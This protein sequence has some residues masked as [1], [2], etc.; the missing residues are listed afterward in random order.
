MPPHPPFPP[1]SYRD[2]ERERDRELSSPVGYGHYHDRERN[3]DRDYYRP[4]P[5]R[6]GSPPDYERFRGR[7][8]RSERP[9]AWGPPSGPSGYGQSR[10][11]SSRGR[12]KEDPRSPRASSAAIMHPRPR[13]REDSFSDRR[14]DTAPPPKS[15]FD[16]TFPPRRP[17]PCTFAQTIFTNYTILLAILFN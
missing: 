10:R 5:P 7:P 6:P 11:D 9:P 12:E 17:S 4:P 16:S 2:R 3:D 15:V 8:P 1:E 14:R 13:D